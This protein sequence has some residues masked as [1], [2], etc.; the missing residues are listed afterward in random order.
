MIV[1]VNTGEPYS[2]ENKLLMPILENLKVRAM[3]FLGDAYYGGSARVLK[4]IKELHMIAVF[5]VKDTLRKKVRNPFRLWAKRNYELRK[6][7][8]RKR[9]G[10]VE[11]S[12]GKAKN[13]MGDR[14]WTKDF[15]TASL[16]VLGRFV[17]LNL[18]LLAELLLLLLRL[19]VLPVFFKSFIFQYKVY[20]PTGSALL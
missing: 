5:P 6:K 9:R 13:S 10:Y 8:Y 14:D 4:K 11:Q 20:F 18:A 17:V 2:D 15:H 3:Y 12:I 16:Y 7:I 1:D 19:L